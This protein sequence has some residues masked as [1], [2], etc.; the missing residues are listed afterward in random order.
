M[1][2]I[3]FHDGADVLVMKLEGS[4]AGACVDETYD[5]WMRIARTRRGRPV[6]VDLRGLCQV[7]AEG[8]KLL[9]LLHLDGAEFMTSGCVMPEIVREISEN[10]DAGYSFVW[11]S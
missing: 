5:C 6:H 2:R 3:T 9:A 7:D 11:R 4:L 10:A 1:F 8:R